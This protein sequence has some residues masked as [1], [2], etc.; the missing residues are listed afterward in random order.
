VTGDFQLGVDVGGTFTDLVLWDVAG[1][2]VRTHKEL[3]TPAQPADG[4]F[5]GMDRLLEQSG[6]DASRIGRFVH[7]TTLVAN[8]ILERKGAR[9]ALV[10]TRGFRDI[11]E[12]RRELR[13]D[14]FE[15]H[16]EFPPPLVPR[17]R[18]LE[19]DERVDASG[20]V[21][22]APTAAEIGAVV[23]QIAATGATSVAVALMHAYA[24]PVHEEALAAAIVERLPGLPVSLSSAVLPQIREYERTSA[25]VINA[26]VRPVIRRYLA[27]LASG[28]AA[29]GCEAPVLVMTSTGGVVS[30]E[31]AEALPIL[32][33][34]SGPSAGALFAARLSAAAGR[35]NLV[36]FDM[37]GTTAKVCVIEDG[38]PLTR[39]DHE[40]ARTARFRAGSGLPVGIPVFD[41]LEIGAGGGSIAWLDATGVLRVGP[42]S[43]GAD[44]GPACY[45][46]GGARPTV[47]DANLLLGYL[48]ADV[49][50]GGAALDVAAARRAL[51][52][53]IAEPLGVLAIEAAAAVHRVVTETM[54][55]ALRVR[56][57]EHNVDPASLELVSFGGAAGLHA[58]EIARRV[59]IHR[60]VCP[61]R[62]GVFSAAG[63]LAASLAVDAAQTR[64]AELDTLDSSSVGDQFA[65]LERRAE[66]EL[67]RAGLG[68]A[69]LTYAADMSYVGQEFEIDVAIPRLPQ[70]DDGVAALAALFEDRY[71][72]LRGRR[73]PGYQARIVTWRVRASGGEPQLTAGFFAS[74]ARDG[75]R[76]AVRPIFLRG[77]WIE[78]SVHAWDAMRPDDTVPGPAI[79]QHRDT[80]LL[81]PADGSVVVDPARRLVLSIGVGAVH[82]R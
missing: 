68:S 67:A 6:V 78:A 9:T 76:T 66:A 36:A 72:R 75:E 64:I 4:I 38:R 25:T 48:G 10:A 81:V 23:D 8:A 55:E 34:E 69:R 73:L 61:P 33:V 52:R 80:A 77:E 65:L 3:T 82:A 28:L 29:R 11:L 5:T 27:E 70:D 47:T 20:R 37:G 26:Y 62:S 58:A 15:Q 21:R 32:L 13:Y 56:A 42:E 59:G 31:T 53:D 18:R 39:T 24:N 74:E 1:D 44:P 35:P 71:E 14:L 41:L 60:V 63:L 19:L 50:F 51:E 79:V 22:R 57:V 49:R 17:A 2:V 43:A 45:G 12:I 16:L 40:V 54:A 30:H 46:L 7:A